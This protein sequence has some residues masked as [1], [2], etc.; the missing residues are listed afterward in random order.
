MHIGNYLR[1]V[2]VT[3]V[4]Y[5]QNQMETIW[6]DDG[7]DGP[8]LSIP[9]PFAGLGEGIFVG[10]RPG[11]IVVVDRASYERYIPL[12]TIPMRAFSS[13][14]IG[15]IDDLGID[16][17]P[18][19]EIDSGE[20]YIQSVE[21]SGV[22]LDNVGNVQ[23][24]NPFGEGSFLGGDSSRATRVGIDVCPPTKYIVSDSGLLVNGLVRRDT[25]LE[26]QEEFE[27]ISDPLLDPLYEQVLEEV[28]RDPT[29]NVAL[30]SPD[31]QTSA[32]NINTKIFRNPG[33]V[34][35][36]QLILEYG[37]DWAVSTK[38]NE[39]KRL[40]EGIVTKKNPTHRSE[41]RNNVLGLSLNNPNELIEIVYGTLVDF[42]GSPLDLN[43]HVLPSFTAKEEEEYY[44]KLEANARKTVAFLK[45][46]NTRKGYSYR[47]DGPNGSIPKIL[48]GAPDVSTAEN[49]ARDRSKWSILVD[50]EGL[51][52]L[53]IPA[54]SETGNV[55][56]LARAENSSSVDV[57]SDGNAKKTKPKDTLTVNRNP[58]KSQDIHLDQVGPGG[59]TVSG[60]KYKNR[61]AGED[62][63]WIENGSSAKE[64]PSEIQ[65]GMAFH[66]ITKTA[67][68]LLKKDANRNA[69]DV[70]AESP[71][72]VAEDGG[73]VKNSI[74]NVKPSITPISAL[75]DEAGRINNCPNAGGRSIQANL[76]GNLELSI[77]ANTVD[78]V[79]WMLDTAGGIVARLGRDRYGRSAVIQS[80]GSVFLEVGGYDY[81]GE[82]SSDKTD[83]RFSGG[84]TSRSS[85]LPKDKARF[86]AGKVV[87]KIK[88]STTT[89]TA[90]QTIIIDESGITLDSSK[91][92]DINSKGDL[93]LQSKAAI[94]IDAPRVKF[95]KGDM[96]REVIRSQRP[97]T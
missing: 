87:I 60:Q 33:L 24:F 76:D 64:Q 41:R 22:Y 37:R 97:I 81:V 93:N 54:S 49:N 74:D 19:P 77:G 45:E 48:N 3:S 9:H 71:P 56:V 50:K 53:N 13:S 79:S 5:S 84:G 10:I 43:K 75:R 59:I 58:K 32:K 80:D 42:F 40:K 23:F 96:S 83:T 70:S 65:A 68:D 8:T 61:L 52:K 86:K 38:A 31:Q 36:R 34:E 66:D 25:N 2:A 27:L 88:G 91:R 51:T 69:S 18:Y 14:D 92:I 1:L 44:D 90:D 62:A 57:D 63:G 7:E 16:S 30:M 29:K 17:I 78:R 35:S 46:I 47:S 95:F 82:S 67:A 6:L 85:A 15:D 28:G 72:A 21:G 94:T 20:I 12:A 11:S 73:A 89:G 39:L 55:P 4:D 26:S